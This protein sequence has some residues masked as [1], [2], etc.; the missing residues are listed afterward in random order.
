MSIG[1]LAQQITEDTHAQATTDAIYR[2]ILA[3]M[4]F[5]R[6]RRL[7]FSE[8]S[9]S[10]TLVQGKSVYGPGDGCPADVAE[11]VGDL[12]VLIGGSQNQRL[13]CRRIPSG[14]LEAIK[15]YGTGQDQPRVFDFWANAI[16]FYPTPI[17]STD[18]VEGRFVNDIGVPVAKYE[19]AVWNYYEPNGIRQ[20][21]AAQIAA[22]ENDWTKPQSAGGLV[23]ARAAYL[24]YNDYLHDEDMASTWL[25]RWLEQSAM[26]ETE[27]EAKTAGATRVTGTILD[28]WTDYTGWLD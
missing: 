25:N 24:L 1:T 21:T 23:L 6:D 3:S 4:R 7:W 8:R 13:P 19:S 15:I 20:L 26:L 17:S 11:I 10:F 27:S 9:F 12:W 22:W 14:N 28:A 2:S 5:H 16:R 18:T